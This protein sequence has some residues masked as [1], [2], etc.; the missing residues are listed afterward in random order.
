MNLGA[1]HH[2]ILLGYSCWPSCSG[3]FP[4]ARDFVTGSGD[5]FTP[6]ITVSSPERTFF[7]DAS[8]FGAKV[9]DKSSAIQGFACGT[10]CFT[11]ASWHYDLE[12]PDDQPGGAAFSRL[13]PRGC[14]AAAAKKQPSNRFG[15]R[16]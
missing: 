11:L 12:K 15:D 8:R 10:A 3:S 9:W 4:R 14:E 5:R 2:R 6:F 7:G 1:F 16:A 13:C